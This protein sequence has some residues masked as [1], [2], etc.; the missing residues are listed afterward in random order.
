MFGLGGS[1][2]L[3]LLIILI[4]FMLFPFSLGYF[5]G[6]AKGRKEKI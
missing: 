2:I 1:E 3:V 5:I 4:L 6:L